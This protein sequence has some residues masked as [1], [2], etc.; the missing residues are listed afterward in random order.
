MILCDEIMFHIWSK[1]IENSSQNGSIALVW[2]LY[3]RIKNKNCTKTNSKQKKKYHFIQIQYFSLMSINK[4]MLDDIVDERWMNSL[5]I[6]LV[7]IV[8]TA[9]CHAL[10]WHFNIFRL[11]VSSLFFHKIMTILTCSVYSFYT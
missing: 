7:W 3:F 8:R 5:I 1:V 11:F 2:R 6:H 9:P 10:C 4:L